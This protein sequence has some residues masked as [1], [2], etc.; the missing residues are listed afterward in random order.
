MMMCAIY[1]VVLLKHLYINISYFGTIFWVAGNSKAPLKI[2]AV[3]HSA[4]MEPTLNSIQF[5]PI[6]LIDSRLNNIICI[7]VIHNNL[8]SI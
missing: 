1:L 2:D 7:Q 3:G 8:R 6:Q 5:N 4:S